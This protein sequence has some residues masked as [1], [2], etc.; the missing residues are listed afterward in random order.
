MS[1]GRAWGSVTAIF[2]RTWDL[3]QNT[4]DASMNEVYYNH[5][6]FKG[7]ATGFYFLLWMS[8]FHPSNKWLSVVIFLPPVEPQV[9]PGKCK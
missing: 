5:L 8:P 6:H 4:L 2:P 3:I 7:T 1:S 9:L